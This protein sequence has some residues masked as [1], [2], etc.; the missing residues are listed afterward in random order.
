M[1]AFL[2]ALTTEKC[3]IE[4][5]PEFGSDNV[6]KQAVVTRTLYGMK[7]SARDFRNHLRDCMGNMGYQSCLADPDLWMQ[8]SKLDNGLKYYEYVLLYVDDCLVVSQHPNE[9]LM[10][11]GKYFPLKS[12]SVRPPKFM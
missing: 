8:V 3:W 4:Y 7:Y 5:G 6:G 11:L 9:T 10:R 2:Q 12:E 1:N